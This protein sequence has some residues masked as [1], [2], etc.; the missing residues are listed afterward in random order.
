L[1]D[2]KQRP[3]T[4]TKY[5]ESKVEFLCFMTVHMLTVGKQRGGVNLN[6]NREMFTLPVKNTI[7]KN[8]RMSF[9]ST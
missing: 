9:I 1:S 6:F 8:K 7:L 4:S 5:Q 3:H 2:K